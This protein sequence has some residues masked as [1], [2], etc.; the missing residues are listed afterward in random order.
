VQ[1]TDPNVGGPNGGQI[2]QSEKFLF[3]RGVG[4]FAP[5][6]TVAALGGGKVRVSNSAGTP[7][8]GLVLVT[9]HG[10]QVAFKALGE[11]AG[12]GELTATQ[13]E[14]FVSSADL[15]ALLVKQLTGA[16]LYEKEAQAMVKTWASAWF[17]EDGH[18]LLYL[19]PRSLTDEVLPVTLNP[20]PVELVRVL[21]GRHDFVT[22]EQE[23]EVAKQLRRSQAAQAEYQAAEAELRKVGRFADDARR[24]AAERLEKASQR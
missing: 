1:A 8:R 19:V 3:Y 23:L 9:A 24:M 7:V 2:V 11:I 12:K 21:V 15:G 16:G 4:T 17:G 14:E 5:P 13:P 18:R 20:K 10:G 6:V 22:P